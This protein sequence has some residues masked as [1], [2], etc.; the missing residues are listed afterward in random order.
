AKLFAAPSALHSSPFGQQ[1]IRES[2]PDRLLGS[3]FV[4]GRASARR[5]RHRNADC[6]ADFRL[7]LGGKLRMLL[8]IIARVVLALPDLLAVVRVPGAGFL[9]DVLR[10]AELDHLA[11][12]RD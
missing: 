8:Q 2:K 10:D 5:A 4:G 12:A 6:G 3:L 11:L 7:D 1:R 9:D